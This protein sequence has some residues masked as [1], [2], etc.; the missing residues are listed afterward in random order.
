MS[1]ETVAAPTLEQEFLSN[2]FWVHIF[3]YKRQGLLLH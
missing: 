1:D 2:V 3:C